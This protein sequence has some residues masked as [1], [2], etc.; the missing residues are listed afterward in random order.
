MKRQIILAAAVLTVGLSGTAFASHNPNHNPPATVTICHANGKQDMV[1][2]VTNEN[3]INGHFGNNGTTKQG[4]ED[5]VLKQ[6]EQSCDEAPVVVV[7]DLCEN[8]PD[9]QSTVPANHKQDGKNCTE[10]DAGDYTGGK[11]EPVVTPTP[12]VTPDQADEPVL[13]SFQGK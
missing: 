5:D 13:E 4:H 11:E 3:A 1:R 7:V 9:V 10:L 6:G 8:L 12:V 2:I